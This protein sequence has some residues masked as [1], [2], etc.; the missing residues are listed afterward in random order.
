MDTTDCLKV[1]MCNTLNE[2]YRLAR[3]AFAPMIFHGDKTYRSRGI[4]THE[5]ELVWIFDGDPGILPVD[6]GG[7]RSSYE[8]TD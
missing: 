6:L 5:G 1:G 2:G 3:Y 8:Y 7:N 4:G